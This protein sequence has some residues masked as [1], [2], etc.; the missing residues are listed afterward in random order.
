MTIDELKE[1]AEAYRKTF[2]R[3]EQSINPI[4]SCR[5]GPVDMNMIDDLILALEALDARI[6]NLENK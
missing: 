1:K 6:A 3:N 5:Y 4:E 2:L